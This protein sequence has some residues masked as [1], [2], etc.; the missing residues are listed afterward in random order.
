MLKKITKWETEDGKVFD[1]Q[2]EAEEYMFEQE[3]GVPRDKEIVEC[4]E[5]G[6][7]QRPWETD[8]GHCRNCGGECHNINEIYG[9]DGEPLDQRATQAAKH[10]EKP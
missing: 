2:E 1:T 8:A 4:I 9:A 5:C 3:K 6:D 10:G 7:Q